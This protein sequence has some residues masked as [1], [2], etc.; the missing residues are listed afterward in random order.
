VWL[1]VSHLTDLFKEPG[2]NNHLDHASIMNLAPSVSTAWIRV[3][4][5]LESNSIYILLPVQQRSFSEDSGSR[6]PLANSPYSLSAASM[7]GSHH[8]TFSKNSL[9]S[10]PSSLDLT[11]TVHGQRTAQFISSNKSQPSSMFSFF[12]KKPQQSKLEIAGP[13]GQSRRQT[14]VD[15]ES[16][17][18][19]LS[20][21]LQPT[22]QLSYHCDVHRLNLCVD[23][24]VCGIQDVPQT[25]Q[26]RTNVKAS[27]TPK[28]SGFFKK[29]SS[30]RA[31]ADSHVGK[32][33]KAE[34]ASSPQMQAEHVRYAFTL[35]SATNTH[36]ILIQSEGSG[37][38]SRWITAIRGAIERSYL[39]GNDVPLGSSRLPPISQMALRQNMA[40]HQMAKT[41]DISVDVGDNTETSDE[42]DACPEWEKYLDMT[43]ASIPTAHTQLAEAGSPPKEHSRHSVRELVTQILKGSPY[44]AECGKD[45][46]DWVSL[47]L[48]VCVCIECSGVHRSLG[49]HV[50]KVRSIT[51]DNLDYEAYQLLSQINNQLANS[52]WEFTLQQVDQKLLKRDAALTD[53]PKV[54]INV[55]KYSPAKPSPESNALEREMFI[56]A[57]Y[58]RRMY[59]DPEIS[60]FFHE[61]G[62]LMVAQRPTP[63]IVGVYDESCLDVEQIEFDG[64]DNDSHCVPPDVSGDDHWNYLLGRQRAMTML[65]DGCRDHDVT[66]VLRAIACLKTAE[67][68]DSF[69]YIYAYTS[70]TSVQTDVE[71]STSVY[72]TAMHVCAFYNSPI[73]LVLLCL[74]GAAVNEVANFSAAAT[75][76]LLQPRAEKA[77]RREEN[78]A[79]DEVSNYNFLDKG[80]PRPPRSFFQ[81]PAKYKVADRSLD[82]VTTNTIALS[83]SNELTPHDLAVVLRHDDVVQY[84]GKKYS[85]AELTAGKSI[86]PEGTTSKVHSDPKQWRWFP[87][88]LVGRKLSPKALNDGV[89]NIST[90]GKE[91]RNKWLNRRQQFSHGGTLPSSSTRSERI[92]PRDMPT[93][94]A[95][96]DVGFVNNGCFSDGESEKQSNQYRFSARGRV[97]SGEQSK[98]NTGRATKSG[99][100]STVNASSAELHDR[101][102]S[103]HDLTEIDE[104]DPCYMYYWRPPSALKRAS[105]S[106]NTDFVKAEESYFRSSEL[107]VEGVV[108]TSTV[109]HI[110]T[111]AE[112]CDLETGSAS[113]QLGTLSG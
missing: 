89:E 13:Q 21:H 30:I 8:S 40:G 103:S 1:R 17:L 39:T 53:N 57:K 75:S 18:P 29:S 67:L 97:N 113:D 64:A 51:L 104:Y 71:A 20:D 46:P 48:C 88:K 35:R 86:R 74:N 93:E 42:P 65:F 77:C 105:D 28:R 87:G 72:S 38:Q 92:V 84:L 9:L 10:V 19:D 80:N 107:C 25:A 5:V 96:V 109:S 4:M 55:S 101:A 7:D 50:S 63:P 6:E 56:R 95:E 3:W 52:I 76:L 47:N 78:T 62:A 41:N 34:D 59:V 98:W 108:M 44:C 12:Q 58:E 24:R 49:T 68:S 94:I 73:A 54:M 61:K 15:S 102:E 32:D 70:S 83:E 82:V 11:P 106:S 37:E 22:S 23:L 43:V 85:A 33:L 91:D 45:N 79:G 26:V 2:L 66:S 69:P 14:L 100:R 90:V 27:S 99:V 81:F 36:I 110:R 31:H 112:Y 16:S 60:S 111:A